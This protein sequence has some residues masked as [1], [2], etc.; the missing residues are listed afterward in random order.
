MALEGAAGLPVREVVF[1]FLRA[2]EA[3]QPPSGLVTFGVDER[4]R[5]VVR[6]AL[7][8]AAAKAEA[9]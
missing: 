9:D 1:A 3:G 5:E 6:T 8:G 7:V 4:A 2:G